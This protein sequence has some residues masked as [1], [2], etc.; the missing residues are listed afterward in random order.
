MMNIIDFLYQIF[1]KD[2]SLDFSYF[3]KIYEVRDSKCL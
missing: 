3:V 1:K 2:I